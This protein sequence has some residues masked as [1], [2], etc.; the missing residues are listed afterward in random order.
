MGTTFGWLIAGSNLNV[1]SV[2]SV[3]TFIIYFV[4]LGRKNTRFMDKT[5]MCNNFASSGTLAVKENGSV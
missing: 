5:I 2:A 3:S 4:S 1:C